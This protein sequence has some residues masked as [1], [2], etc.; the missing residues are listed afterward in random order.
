MRKH[1]LIPRTD[2]ASTLDQTPDPSPNTPTIAPAPTP[3]ENVRLDAVPSGPALGPIAASDLRTAEPDLENVS[4]PASPYS[5]NRQLIHSITLPP[6][7][8]VDIPPSPPGSPRAST[9]AKMA[10]FLE[11]KKSGVH[12]NDKLASSSALKNPSLLQNLMGFA[13]INERDQ[14]ATTLPDALKPVPQDGFPYYAYDDELAR[15]QE[16]LSRKME[17]EKAGRDK[18][19]FVSASASSDNAA[20]VPTRMSRFDK[21]ERSPK[22]A[23]KG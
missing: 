18:V 17:K 8:N 12:F 9:S 22:R 4:A 11:L 20:K 3:Q 5:S 19:D 7:P 13:G 14:F 16:R 23:K 10:R 15:S 6:V 21:T 1:I 2:G